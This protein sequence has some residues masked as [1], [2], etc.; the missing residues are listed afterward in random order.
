M[1]RRLGAEIMGVEPGRG[2]DERPA[3]THDYSVNR[4]RRQDERP[5]QKASPGAY[6]PAGGFARATPAQPSLQ[7]GQNALRVYA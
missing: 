2:L 4:H 6:I 1:R 5:L 7:F 3:G